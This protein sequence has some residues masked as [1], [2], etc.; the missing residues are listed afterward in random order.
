[1][2]DPQQ[3]VV[4]L[5]H[6]A[7]IERIV[8]RLAPEILQ[9]VID[10]CGLEACGELLTLATPAQLERVLDLDLWR[11]PVPGADE[12]FDGG[13]FGEW[14]EMLAQLEPEVAARRLAA[15]P[16]DVVAGGLAQHVRV[17]DGAAVSGYTT[18]DGDQV[19]GRQIDSRRASEIGGFL[20]EA[21][22]SSVWDAI[23][24]LL[25]HLAAEHTGLFQR[26]MRACVA[27]SSGVRELDGCDTLAGE[28]DQQLAELAADRQER[29]DRQGYLDAAQ[30]R[31]FL[32]RGRECAL[33][34]PRLERDAVAH[35]YLRDLAPEPVVDDAATSAG[36]EVMD[37]LS[38]AGVVAPSQAML[39]AGPPE[40]DRL[41]RVRALARSSATAQQELA[42]LTNTLLSGG[43]IH[44]RPLTPQEASDM[45]GATCNLGL[46]NWPPLWGAP[47][48]ITA[49]QAGWGLLHRDVCR[50]AAQSLVAVLATLHCPD[51]DLQWSLQTLRR[52]LIRHLDAGAPWRACEQLDAILTLDAPAW[53]TLLSL[54]A[55]CPTLHAALMSPRLLRID[56]AA[57]SFIA[58]NAEIAIARAWL[59]T[60]GS[61]L[62][63]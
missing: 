20:V 28:R 37:M 30:A 57:A 22:W 44:G 58:G 35:A 47:D 9:R 34:G 62:S 16:P 43:G 53:A 46:E 39:P 19:A 51:R 40:N 48:L 60:L 1:M 14:L 21:R 50:H 10:R 17:F 56:P 55:E 18:L 54:I 4:R 6:T 36:A 7:G 31:A 63:G 3:L 13:R 8:P 52:D 41:A 23:V 42:F 45:V 24:E 49:F 61:V 25:A 11:A 27:V 12:V 38:D 32:Q 33:D 59:A 2:S 29:R 5:L 15:M 26:L